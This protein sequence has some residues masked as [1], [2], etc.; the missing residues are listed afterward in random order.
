MSNLCIGIG[1]AVVVRVLLPALLLILCLFFYTQ[2]L[3]HT[4]LLFCTHQCR[5]NCVN[6]NVYTQYRSAFNLVIKNLRQT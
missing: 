4:V 2:F 1:A 5:D 6:L 3:K